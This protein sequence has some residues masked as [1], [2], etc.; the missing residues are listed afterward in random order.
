ME[1]VRDMATDLVSDGARVKVCVQQA[2]GQGVF[3][4]KLMHNLAWACKQSQVDACS[5]IKVDASHAILRCMVILQL[6]TIAEAWVT[7]PAWLL[8]C[9]C[10]RCIMR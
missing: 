6:A 3:Q 5:A 2:L 10:G 8:Q 7:Q 4:V 1:L 9:P